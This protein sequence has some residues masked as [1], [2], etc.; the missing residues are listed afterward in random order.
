MSAPAQP[1]R[2]AV[3]E[4][5]MWPRAE[6]VLPLPHPVVCQGGRSGQQT[7]VSTPQ[8]CSN[9]DGRPWCAQG[10]TSLILEWLSC[11]V[12]ASTTET[13][14]SS[15]FV[16]VCL[17]NCGPNRI[18]PSVYFS[19]LIVLSS[20]LVRV[21]LSQLM[22]FRFTPTE[23]DNALLQLLHLTNICHLPRIWPHVS[24]VQQYGWQFITR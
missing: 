20:N 15:T 18:I 21:V 22:Y 23:S 1:A 12:T 8:P 19:A 16:T 7:R 2:W 17:L 3:L 9:K 4:K 5:S 14:K 13:T 10:L 11:S 6:E 24:F